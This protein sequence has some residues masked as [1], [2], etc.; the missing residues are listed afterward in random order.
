M[1]HASSTG[2]VFSSVKITDDGFGKLN[3]VRTDPLTQ[4]TTTIYSGIGEI[5]YSTGIIKFNGKFAPISIGNSQRFLTIT[6]T[7]LNTDIFS[8]ENKILRISRVHTDSVSISM[9]PYEIR[10]QFTA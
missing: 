10:K 7:P 6:V 4:I 9:V 5:Y 8:F 3:L 2:T 1:I